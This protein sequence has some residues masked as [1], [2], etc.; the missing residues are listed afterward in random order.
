M[1][2]N[3]VFALT[4][5]YIGVFRGQAVVDLKL[6]FTVSYIFNPGMEQFLLDEMFSRLIGA[7]KFYPHVLR[8]LRNA[9][10]VLAFKYLHTIAREQTQLSRKHRFRQD[11]RA[12]AIMSV[13]GST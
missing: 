9:K 12:E 13:V 6:P 11:L 5:K 7:R 8:A 3:I 2:D 10:G 1:V 4:H